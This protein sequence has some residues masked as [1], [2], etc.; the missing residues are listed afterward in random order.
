MT[1]LIT[2][3]PFTSLL[4]RAHDAG[5]GIAH[6]HPCPAALPGELVIT[7]RCGPWVTVLSA[8]SDCPQGAGAA[9]RA[10]AEATG[11]LYAERAA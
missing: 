1:P 4:A 5:T 6:S 9:A 11:A 8:E 2:A 10:W 7:E 3:E